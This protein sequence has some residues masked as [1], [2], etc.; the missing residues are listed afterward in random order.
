MS[1]FV[2]SLDFELFWGVHDARGSEYHQCI[3]Y[4]H[5][6][7]PELLKVFKEYDVKVTWATVGFI[8]IDSFQEFRDVSE[9]IK[10]PSYTDINYSPFG[11]S[12]LKEQNES[13]VFAPQ[14][15]QQIVDCGH[16][17]GSHTMSHYYVLE[18]GQCKAEFDSDCRS[19][20][21]LFLR[22]FGVIPKSIVFPRNQVN[23]SYLNIL[24]SNQ[25]KCFRGTPSHWA[26]KTESRKQR[27]TLK[28]IYRLLDSYLPITINFGCRVSKVSDNLINVP[29]TIFFRP[30]SKALSF[31]ESFKLW[32][33]KFAMTRAALKGELF[34]LWWH[35][36]NFSNNTEENIKNLEKIL[37]HYKMLSD[38]YNWK[39]CT[40]L[41]ATSFVS[42]ETESHNS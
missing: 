42:N 10:F 3:K 13:L 18:N 28:R 5:Q 29:A 36:H 14:L 4:V 27:S 35:P 8:G 1:A 26:Y 25:I 33:I 17:L 9:E 34:H 2:I 39:N 32:R 12:F 6:V 41:E 31:L 37:S 15:I 16:E 22:K 20:A 30:Y 40:M 21:K 23:G 19:I 24:E 11:K 38:K 7:V